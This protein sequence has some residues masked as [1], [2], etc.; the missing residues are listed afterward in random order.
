MSGE[1][2]RSVPVDRAETMRGIRTFAQVVQYLLDD[3]GWPDALL[4][5]LV[6]DDLA[7]VTY[8]WD[9]E[10]LGI[11]AEQLRDLKRLQQM[12]PLRARANR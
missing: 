4:D 7:E 2:G 8:D 10:E 11:P 3:Q 1:P 9:P 5:H 6:D 12:R